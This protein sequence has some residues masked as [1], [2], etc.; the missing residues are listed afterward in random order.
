MISVAKFED[1]ISKAQIANTVSSRQGLADLCWEK[2]K[3]LEEK[4]LDYAIGEIMDRGGELRLTWK[5]IC[6]LMYAS[7]HSGKGKSGDTHWD[8]KECKE[9]DMGLISLNRKVEGYNYT[10]VF[11]CSFC[12]SYHANFPFLPRV[13][14]KALQAGADGTEIFSRYMAGE[15]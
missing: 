1:G 3:H 7:Q 15:K 6:S 12:A 11:K 2:C 10:Y 4:D 13:L 5:N 14:I 8:G 9:C